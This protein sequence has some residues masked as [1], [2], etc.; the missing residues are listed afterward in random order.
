MQAF[1]VWHWLVAGAVFVTVWLTVRYRPRPGPATKA[2][3]KALGGGW[4][5]LLAF[6]SG[7]GFMLVMLSLSGITI[8]SLLSEAGVA[9]S[10]A[11]LFSVSLRVKDP[12]SD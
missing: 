3:A 6:C 9:K 2:P 4:I 7:L 12:L 5:F 8:T 10:I 11:S 1:S